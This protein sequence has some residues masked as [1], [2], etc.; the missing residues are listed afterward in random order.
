MK[1]LIPATVIL[2]FIIT[3]C[4]GAHLYVNNAC[5]QTLSGLKAYR[6]NT[7]TADSLK[8]SWQKQKE[9]MALFVN[10]SF[11]DKITIYVGQLTLTPVTDT[12]EFDIIYNNIESVI[13]LIKAEQKLAIHSFY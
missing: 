2:I 1:R 5:E 7:I 4:I 3:I 11:L 6:N 10:H 9:Q 13:E 8:N 12:H